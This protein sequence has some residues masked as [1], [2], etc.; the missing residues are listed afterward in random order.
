[1]F[2]TILYAAVFGETD[3]NGSSSPTPG[4]LLPRR[5]REPDDV[6]RHVGSRR[7]PAAPE[8]LSRAAIDRRRRADGDEHRALRAGAGDG[9]VA[10]HG[11]R[12]SSALRARPRQVLVLLRA[13][14]EANAEIARPSITDLAVD[15]PGRLRSSAARPP[16]PQ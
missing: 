1:M 8:V 14:G 12:L 11:D 4:D 6:P 9:G 5:G 16:R 15:W 3:G 2:T 10:G 7:R 13:R